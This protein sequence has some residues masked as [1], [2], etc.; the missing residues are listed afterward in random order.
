MTTDTLSDHNQRQFFAADASV[1]RRVGDLALLALRAWASLK[2]TVALFALAIILI[3]VGTLAQVKM[4]MWEVISLYFRSW[5]A[6]INVAVLFPPSWFPGLQPS[7]MGTICAVSFVGLGFA[8]AVCCGAWRGLPQRWRMILGAAALVLLA[9]AALTVSRGG[10]W[11]PGGATI[12]TLL[13]ANLLA[14]QLVRFTVQARGLRLWAGL[15]GIAAGAVTTWVVISSGHNPEGFQAV[16]VFSWAALWLWCKLALTGLAILNLVMLA[17]M[18]VQSRQRVIELVL[19]SVSGVLLSL[20]AVWLWL[21]GDGA[22]LGDAGMRILWQLIQGGLAAAVVLAG[23]VL[24]FHRRGGM[25]LIHIGLALLMLSEVYV[26]FF[27]VEERLIIREGETVNFALDIRETELAIVDPAASQDE[28]EVW[29]IPQSRLIR[30]RQ[31]GEA[32]QERLLPFDVQVTE[33]LKNSDLRRVQGDEQNPATAGNGLAWVAQEVRPDSGAGGSGEVDMASAY[34]T[35]TRKGDGQPIG[36]YLVSQLLAGPRFSETV[37]VGGKDYQLA[38]RFKQTY[39]PYSMHLVDV[40]KVDYIGTSTPK[41]Y[42]SD[43]RLIAPQHN[44]DRPVRIWMNNP[45]RYAGETF[46]QSGYNRDPH[47]GVETTTLQVVTNTGWMIPYVACMFVWFGMQAHFSLMLLRFLTRRD[48]ELL[49]QGGAD[50]APVAPAAPV[51]PVAP[52][53]P[54]ARRP[55]GHVGGARLER[56]GASER[57]AVMFPAAVVLVFATWWAGQARPPRTA[58]NEFD[59]A[60]F[61]ALPVVD[62]GRVKPIDTLART[63]LAKLSDRESYRDAGGQKQPAVRWLLDVVA[64]PSAAESHQVFRVQNLDVLQTL[65]LP[66]RRGFRY[67]LAEIRSQ[68]EKLNEFDKELRAAGQAGVEKMDVYQRKLMELNQR[69]QAYLR[70]VNAFQPWEVP[71]FPAEK[72]LE[73]DRQAAI[74]GWTE[75]VIVAGERSEREMD[76]IQAP[77]VVPRLS[78]SKAADQNRAPADQ[79]PWEAYATAHTRAYLQKTLGQSVNPAALAWNA[80]LDAYRQGDVQAFNREVSQYGELLAGNPPHE[81]APR[82]VRME[83]YMSS[84]APITFCVGLYWTAFVL[85]AAAWLGWSRPLN[86]AAYGLIFLAFCVHTAALLGRMTISGRPPVTNLYSSVVFIGWCFALAGLILEAV[87]RL[88]VCNVVASVGGALTLMIA[89]ALGRGADTFTV[90]Q[91]VLDTQ[92]WLATHVVIIALGYAATFLA[93]LLGVIFIV[94]GV[95]TRSLASA[96]VRQPLARMIYGVVCFA[97]LFSFVGTVLGGLWADDS[98]GRFWGWD[99]KENGA[100]IIVLWN[101]LILHALWDNQVRARGL[102]VLAVAGNIMTAWSWFGVN[103]LGVGLHSYGFTEGVLL[104]LGVFVAS[105]LAVIVVGCLPLSWWASFRNLPEPT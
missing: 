32:I 17:V 103:E 52:V 89:Q 16:P 90:M 102:A 50:G 62:Q 4:D 105:Q 92:F 3:F 41:D 95:F 75:R 23:C 59:Y 55:R 86:R 76:A 93:G 79:K 27:A 97:A 31:R 54:D 37:S 38:L 78:G 85:A 42:S 68:P 34:V 88:G 13:A 18:F 70:L 56:R 15:A 26:S 69:F 80:M 48:E 21:A 29:A 47:S 35:L 39:K 77:L 45:L 63:T 9:Q 67:S 57:G 25:V 58:D 66:R 94:R 73:A 65:G 6:W 84:A 40:R 11:F 99:P 43:V 28:Q 91:A 30:S 2:L 53:A 12:G 24:L 101:A 71:P 60:A 72:E 49:A 14:S 81:Y 44:L 8:A 87:F 10:F 51:T 46:Y 104:A 100:L 22:Y 7:V 83:A 20:L 1:A 33:Y 5:I 36:T 61:A 64:K 96:D 74:R 82:K 98:W 19:M